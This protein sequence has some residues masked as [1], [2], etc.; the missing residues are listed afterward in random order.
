MARKSYV[1]RTMKSTRASIL[2]MDVELAEPVKNI[3]ILAGKYKDADSILKS[4][5]KLIETDRIK[6]VAVDTWQNEE[7]LYR[8]SEDTFLAIA[9]K[10]EK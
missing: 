3:V 10:V 9:E 4:A 5:K 8:L 1:T 6:A 7:A 2:C